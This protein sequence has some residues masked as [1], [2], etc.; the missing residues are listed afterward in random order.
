MRL[1]YILY[2]R[3]LSSISGCKHFDDTACWKYSWYESLHTNT[4]HVPQ[5]CGHSCATPPSCPPMVHSS[6]YRLRSCFYACQVLCFLLG[7]RWARFQCKL[8]HVEMS[9][10]SNV[11][12][13]YPVDVQSTL[14]SLMSGD[15]TYKPNYVT[16]R[17]FPSLDSKFS[18]EPADFKIA[19]HNTFI[20]ARLESWIYC[21][22][23]IE[24]FHGGYHW[25]AL[26]ES[27]RYC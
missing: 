19:K 18:V 14:C 22:S 25:R 5:T 23:I 3:Y 9:L 2:Q 13:W 11:F 24:N 10:G 6:R 16:L 27:R 20:M 4:S 1:K 21:S 26:H 15:F 7:W 17:P 12:S 8:G